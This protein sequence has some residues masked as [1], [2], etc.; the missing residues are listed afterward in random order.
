MCWWNCGITVTLLML[1]AT[2]SWCSWQQ[3][4][5]LSVLLATTSCMRCRH[6]IVWQQ[7]WRQCAIGVVSTVLIIFCLLRLRRTCVLVL[8]NR[9]V[10]RGTQVL[11]NAQQHLRTRL[12]LTCHWW[13][14]SCRRFHAQTATRKCRTCGI[15][16]R[17]VHN[18]DT[19]RNQQSQAKICLCVHVHGAPLTMN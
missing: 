13:R 15:L 19:A 8:N 7:H 1:C 3:C 2:T 16:L 11:W 10:L 6:N 14:L 9:G 4:L 18:I 5:T 12:L 17:V